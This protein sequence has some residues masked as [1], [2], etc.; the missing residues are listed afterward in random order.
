MSYK[1]YNKF[2]ITTDTNSKTT[3]IWNVKFLS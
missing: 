3:Q 1:V 2:S